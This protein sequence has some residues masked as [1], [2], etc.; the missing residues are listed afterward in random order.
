MIISNE[1][2]L[3]TSINI[4]NIDEKTLETFLPELGMN[5][6][7]L[8]EQP[9]ELS[10]YFGKGLKFWQYPNQFSKFLKQIAS[11]KDINSYLEIGC[12]WGGTFII[13]SEI[14]KA[15]NNNVKLFANDL[16]ERSYILNEYSKVQQFE[17]IQKDSTKIKYED[18]NQSIDLVF[19]DGD[20]SYEAVKND[21]NNCLNMFEPK[22][23]VFHDICSQACPGVVKFWNEVKNNYK[24]FEY[25]EQYSS[26]NGNFLGIGLLELQ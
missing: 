10:K 9:I 20:H 21:F 22:Y 5:N 24:Y 14:L 1:L 6:E 12:R 23:A 11:Y 7:I 25:T 19:I 2:Q 17:Y 15:R 3:L 8:N 13:I 16:I 18:I 26:V 4:D